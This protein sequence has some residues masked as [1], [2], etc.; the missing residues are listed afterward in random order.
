MNPFLISSLLLSFFIY[1]PPTLPDQSVEGAIIETLQL[2]T[3]YFCERN[4]K[5][6]QEQWVQKSY[7]SKMYAGNTEFKEFIG[8]QEVNQ[9][10]LD[11]I[12]AN[13][14][15]IPVPVPNQDYNIELLGKT[16]LV[17]YSN[18]N[19]SGTVREIRLM[20]KEEGKWKIAR[21]QTIY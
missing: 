9:N 19:A 21:M 17:F 8:W 11:H 20:I 18:N 6:W 12:K 4:L 10:T 1:Q 2:E 14:E 13:P 5:K 15:K 7:T 16:A 3:R